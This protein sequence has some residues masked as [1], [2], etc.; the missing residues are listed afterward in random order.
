M[1]EDIVTVANRTLNSTPTCRATGIPEPSVSLLRP[2][3]EEVPIVGGTPEF[4]VLR[5][6]D[7]G[8][9]VCVA[10]SAAGEERTEFT[11]TVE[12]SH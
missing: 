11:I 10:S 4:G 2:N 9:Y 7:A 6:A 5:R 12:G 3:G 8:V 1:P